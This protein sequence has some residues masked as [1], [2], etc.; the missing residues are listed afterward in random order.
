MLSHILEWAG[1]QGCR[2][3]LILTGHLGEQ[4]EGFKHDG[5]NLTFVQESEQMGTG[6]AL[7]NAIEYLEDEFILLWGDDYHPVNYRRL[8]ASHK[9]H[10]QSLTMTVIQSD[11]L[12]NLRHENERVFEYSKSEISDSFNGYEAGTSVV[13]K[14]VLVKFGKSKKWS[15]EE[16]VY[17]QM[18]G[19]IH[20]YID[21][22]PFW[23]M[24]TPER[25]ERLEKF[26]DGRRS[27]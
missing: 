7:M 24:G 13:D 22:T 26:F 16:T 25:L 11:E 20:A 2:D 14:S 10:Q 21:E 15:W 27:R 9:E 3:A 1:G 12:A 5:M 4:F 8:Y 6:G 19:Q 23:D 17:P 18:S